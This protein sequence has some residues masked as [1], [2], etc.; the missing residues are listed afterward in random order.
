MTDAPRSIQQTRPIPLRAASER[1]P[2]PLPRP[3]T[4]FIGREREGEE[5]SSL[6]TRGDTS[7]VT[8]VGPAGVGKTR[9]ALQTATAL[10]SAFTLVGFASLAPVTD[11]EQIVPL[12]GTALGIREPSLSRIGEQ[13]ADVPTLLVLDNL[14]QIP[15]AAG[16]VAL[17]LATCASLVALATSRT[18]LHVSGEQ[19]YPVHPFGIDAAPD[20]SS[21][22]ESPAVRLFAERAHAADASFSLDRANL[23]SVARI[24]RELDGLPLAIELAAGQVR[25]LSPQAMLNRLDQRFD[26]LTLGPEDQAERH[27]SLDRAIRWSYDLLALD[28]Q[29]VLRALAIFSGGFTEDAARHI[30][31]AGAPPLPTL[32]S[33]IDASLVLR[34]IQPDGEPR[35]SLLE[36]IRAFCLRE[37]TA[38][39]EEPAVRQAHADYYLQLAAKAEP[40]LIVIGSAEWVHRLGVEHDNLRSAVEWSLARKA[41]DPVL[42]LAGTLLSMAYAKGA[43][44]ESRSWLE[45][46]IALAD[47]VPSAQLSDAHF[48]ASALTQVQ[49]EFSR[50]I[51]HATRSLTIARDAGYAFGEGRALLG[52]G[53]SAEW[54]NDLDLAEQRYCDARAVMRSLDPSTRL[55]HWRVLP[56]AN[57]A[58]IALIRGRYREAIELGTEAVLAWRDAGY[59]WGIA[60]A[61][62]TVAAAHCELGDLAGA[63]RDYRETLDLWLACADGRGIAGTLAGIAAIANYE[64]D[65]IA[66]ASLL[67]SAWGMCD[68]LGLDYLAHHLY[69]EQVRE[70]V[71]STT[72]M[73]A[74]LIDVEAAGHKQP[75]DAAVAAA[76]A[77]LDQEQRT[78]TTVRPTALSPREREV[79]AGIVDGLHDREIAERLSISPR[80]VQS[81]VLAIL[82]KLGARSRAE[83]VAIALRNN[84][85]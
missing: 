4:S 73:R 83:A 58:D 56:T 6:I 33:L 77:V 31:C 50:S 45:R 65:P 69:A 15:G 25:M 26:L 85:I 70:A 17:L 2:P 1:W 27:R 34:T 72:G 63:R 62:G 3:L 48:A 51:E 20:D 23:P 47:P 52:L 13:L 28:Q 60:Q 84:L 57:L 75:L 66:A 38:Q 14:E 10:E 76:M 61:L 5:L 68:L 22:A 80:T 35:F 37:L 19:V 29:Q 21:L 53:I 43:P 81:H 42:A 24:C 8:L 46:A 7:L 49:G 30:A 55:S 67:G 39:E 40:R 82:N 74:S 79:L 41:P 32:A 59:L 54:A 12:A 71:R 44:S 64:G 78:R 11:P 36:S 18:V 16:I 9:L